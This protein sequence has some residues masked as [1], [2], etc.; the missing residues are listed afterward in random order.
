MK[1]SLVRS[2]SRVSRSTNRFVWGADHLRLLTAI[3]AAGLIVLAART[4]LAAGSEGASPAPLSGL[5]D[6]SVT[7]QAT[8]LEVLG[9]RFSWTQ[10]RSYSSSHVSGS[11]I[12]GGTWLSATSDRRLTLGAH[13]AVSLL[14]SLGSKHV[15][16]FS[17][18]KYIASKDSKQTLEKF[19][20]PQDARHTS[21]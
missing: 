4:A 7:E 17:D 10:D 13:N 6:G 21:G 18:G 15:F 16:S 9:P 12:M 11:A 14:G 1:I 2:G 20:R 19:D 8:D 3:F 5:R